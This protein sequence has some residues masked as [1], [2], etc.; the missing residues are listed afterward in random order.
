[1]VNQSGSYWRIVSYSSILIFLI[2]ICSFLFAFQIQDLFEDQFKTVVY[3]VVESAVKQT[4][5]KINN[6]VITIRNTARELADRNSFS[7]YSVYLQLLSNAS[8]ADFSSILLVNME[9]EC[10][11]QSETALWNHS[12]AQEPFFAAATQ[13]Y[14]SVTYST[15]DEQ[16]GKHASI[17]ICEPVRSGNIVSAVLI[18][19]YIDKKL[20]EIVKQS[21]FDGLAA[22]NI[23]TSTGSCIAGSLSSYSQY[24]F[25]EEDNLLFK[26]DDRLFLLSELAD[27]ETGWY[28]YEVNSRSCSLVYMPL[29]IQDLYL[30]FAVQRDLRAIGLP[31]VTPKIL[32]FV[33]VNAVLF[34]LLIVLCV[35][36]LLNQRKE[37]YHSYQEI[38]SLYETIPSPI[39]QIS[40]DYNLTLVSANKPFY[41]LTGYNEGEIKRLTDIVFAEYV[42]LLRNLTSDTKEL[43]FQILCQDGKQKWISGRFSC[44]R[45]NRYVSCSFIDISVRMQELDRIEE[46]ANTDSMTGLRNKQF[47]VARI[48]SFLANGG[49]GGVLMI[50][51]LDNFKR[52]NDTV[53]HPEGDILL[54][55]F[56][57]CLKNHFREK[58]ITARFGGDEFVVFIETEISCELLEK[59]LSLFF[60]KIRAELAAYYERFSLSVSAGAAWVQK[61]DTYDILY[62]R[63]DSALYMSKR[64]G[65]DQFTILQT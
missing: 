46:S 22:S 64:G 51:D 18:G 28:D 58:D 40:L 24:L 30:L 5:L 43:D 49:K 57:S 25:N 19:L 23:V 26:E 11:F 50:F 41:D 10:Y 42:P 2:I 33:I 37:L 17:I 31:P 34:I 9:G 55:K 36:F 12:I 14:G 3:E 60:E 32:F 20:D 61:G 21:F 38:S 1:M 53:G 39:V 27:G 52:V 47:A 16:T 35:Y 7:D 15:P 6:A 65:K 13:G 62:A 56:A 59:K 4:Q 44:Y 48:K 54:K 8:E 45:D 29:E 63:A